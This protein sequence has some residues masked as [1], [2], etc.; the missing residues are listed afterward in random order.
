M[1]VPA[2]GSLGDRQSLHV[3]LV[4][5]LTPSDSRFTDLRLDIGCSLRAMRFSVILANGHQHLG[6]GGEHLRILLKQASTRGKLAACGRRPSRKLMPGSGRVQ[7]TF[8][9]F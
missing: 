8:A 5:L 2:V 4:K 3:S 7:M 9:T 6:C 1:G